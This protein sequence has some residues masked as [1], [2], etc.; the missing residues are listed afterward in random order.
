MGVSLQNSVRDSWD[1]ENLLG[2]FRIVEDRAFLKRKLVTFKREVVT[3]KGFQ[4]QL[5]DV[6]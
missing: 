1:F 4:T 6:F 2:F 5:F 3:W